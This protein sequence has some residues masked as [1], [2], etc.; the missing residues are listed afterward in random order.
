MDLPKVGLG[1]IGP[2]PRT[3]LHGNREMRVAIDAQSGQNE[4][5]VRQLFREAMTAISSP[6]DDPRAIARRSV[7]PA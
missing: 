2:D 5:F 7:L 1:R 3:M 6:C 4:D